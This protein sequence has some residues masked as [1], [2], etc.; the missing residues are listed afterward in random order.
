M[1]HFIHHNL[2][3]QSWMGPARDMSV[4]VVSMVTGRAGQ[5]AG[6]GADSHATTLPARTHTELH[7][8]TGRCRCCCCY[9]KGLLLKMMD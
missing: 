1:M 5:E 8:P 3:H 7:D 9:F 2:K 6:G 4:C